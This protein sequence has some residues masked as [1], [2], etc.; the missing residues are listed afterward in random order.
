MGQT[1]HLKTTLVETILSHALRVE[2]TPTE[3]GLRKT[4]F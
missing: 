1:F 2:A 3:T 4:V